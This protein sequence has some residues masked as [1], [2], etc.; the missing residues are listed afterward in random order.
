MVALAAV[1]DVQMRLGRLLTSDETTAAS[2]LLDEASALARGWMRCVPDPVPGEVVIVVSRMVAR[3]LASAA[4]MQGMS[5]PY[6][7]TQMQDQAGQVS[8]SRSFGDG[9]TTSTVLAHAIV[10]EGLKTLA[11]GANLLLD[12]AFQDDHGIALGSRVSLTAESF[13]PEA[14]EG[15]LIAATRTHYTLRRTDPRVGTVHVH[16][17]RIG[18]VLK[19]AETP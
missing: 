6:G 15:E 16:F 8:M 1:D 18:Y 14:T 10:T 12:S 11:A 2:G 7:T 9:T 17:P 19:K 5:V 13:G 4:S 3:V